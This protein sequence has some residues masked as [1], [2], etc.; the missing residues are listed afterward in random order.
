MACG[1]MNVL[2]ICCDINKRRINQGLRET[3]E[4][5][6]MQFSNNIGQK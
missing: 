4:A 6:R 3:A 2:G 5:D 1:K